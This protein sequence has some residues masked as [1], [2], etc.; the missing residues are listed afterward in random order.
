M[1]VTPDQRYF[2]QQKRTGSSAEPVL[3][4][5]PGAAGQK[6]KVKPVEIALMVALPIVSLFWS[7]L[8]NW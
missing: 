2:K 4:A 3:I 6:S 5:E 8:Q 1:Q 7:R